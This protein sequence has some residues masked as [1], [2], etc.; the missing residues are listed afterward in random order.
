MKTATDPVRRPKLPKLVY[1]GF[2]TTPAQ[3]DALRAEAAKR[4]LKTSG[5]VRMALETFLR[6]AR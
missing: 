2:R 4:N 1:I 3:A 5:M 6:E